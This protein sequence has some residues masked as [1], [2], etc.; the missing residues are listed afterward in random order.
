MQRGGADKHY[1]SATRSNVEE[2]QRAVGLHP[3]GAFDAKTMAAMRKAAREKHRG[4][5]G[6]GQK[7]KAVAR[8]ERRLSRAGYKTRTDGVYDEKTAK[9]AGKWG[10][11]FG[12]KVKR[13]L[14]GKSAQKALG[15][16]WKKT[17]SLERDLKAVHEHPGKVDGKYTHQ[18]QKA[19]D[20]F[21]KKHHLGGVGH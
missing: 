16:Q 2:F 7:S 19:V 5:E 1:T 21:R 10:H 20:H 8:N 6:P 12:V 18:T 3:T 13:G 9:A 14:L 15:N 11:D 4:V 17:E